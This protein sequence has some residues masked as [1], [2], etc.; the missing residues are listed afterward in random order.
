MEMA[1]V[2]RTVCIIENNGT[3]G[4]GPGF[5]FY[6]SSSLQPTKSLSIVSSLMK[7]K[8]IP[9]VRQNSRRSYPLF[10]ELKYCS[11]DSVLQALLSCRWINWMWLIVL[12]L[13]PSLTTNILL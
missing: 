5:A 4:P 8:V 12:E 13:F 3:A 11:W 1:T 9:C 10:V 6:F 2:M 7:T